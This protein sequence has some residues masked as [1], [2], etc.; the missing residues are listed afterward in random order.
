LILPSLIQRGMYGLCAGL[1]VWFLPVM[2]SYRTL[3]E[4]KRYQQRQ[5]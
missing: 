3:N 4:A 1:T 2:V 5:G